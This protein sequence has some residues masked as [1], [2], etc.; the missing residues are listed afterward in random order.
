MRSKKLP[1]RPIKIGISSCLMGDKVR[2]NGDHKHDRYI[3]GIL[4]QYF[5]FVPVCPELEI[6]MGVP[7]ESV[8]LIGTTDVPRMIGDISGKDWTG[9][10]NKYSR[11]RV[12]QQDLQ[13]L[14]GYLFKKDSPSCGMERVKLYSGKGAP[15]KQAVGLFAGALVAR[16]PVLPIE[17]EGRLN[18]PRL[19]ENFIVRIFAFYNLRE[20]FKGKFNRG[21][22]V[23][24]HARNKYLILAHSL[25]HYKEL[26]QLVAAVSKLTTLEFKDQYLSLFMEALRIKTTTRKNVNVLQHILG[27]LKND[28]DADDKKYLLDVIEDYRNE[29][30]PLIVPIS[31]LKNYLRKHRIKHILDQT[32]LNPHPMELMLR[33]HV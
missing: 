1:A 16:Y 29:R 9:R 23:E 12:R 11:K 25:K 4:G 20:L 31:L 15:S 14:S 21:K 3:T 27:F 8:R 18:D 7:R 28:L 33:N 5:S 24:F 10:M 19:R 30:V 6:G 2:F 22:V 13:G 17:E 26:G 32:Y